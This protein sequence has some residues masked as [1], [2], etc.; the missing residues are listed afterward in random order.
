MHSFAS[1]SFFLVLLSS[2]WCKILLESLLQRHHWPLGELFVEV[3]H[4]NPILKCSYKH[5]LDWMT[6]LIIDSLKWVRYSLSDTK[7]PWR[8]F[9]KLV[10]VTFLCML[11]GNWWANFFTKSWKLVTR[12]LRKPIYNIMATSLNVLDI[13]ACTSRSQRHIIAIWMLIEATCSYGLVRPINLVKDGAWSSRGQTSYIYL[14]IEFD[15]L[16]L[17]GHPP[18]LLFADDVGYGECHP[19]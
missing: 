18:C 14:L 16:I 2:P 7:G 1:Q 3:S 4:P 9:N 17:L 12:S 8:M 6:T 10:V 5:F 13:W 11:V 19:P 15:D